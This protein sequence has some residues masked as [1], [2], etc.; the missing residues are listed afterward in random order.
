[1]YNFFL[2]LAILFVKI[3][4]HYCKGYKHLKGFVA[5]CMYEGVIEPILCLFVFV[6]I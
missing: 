1:M 5:Y 2:I 6:V 4:G 3:S